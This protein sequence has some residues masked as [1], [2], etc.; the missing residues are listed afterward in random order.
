[1]YKFYYTNI[2]L[3]LRQFEVGQEY[4]IAYK[5]GDAIEDYRIKITLVA[6]TFVRADIIEE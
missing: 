6:G 1:M 2:I 3:G 5:V 4:N